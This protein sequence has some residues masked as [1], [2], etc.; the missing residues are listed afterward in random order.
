MLQTN[1]H[2]GVLRPYIISGRF[3]DMAS[4]SAM[5]VVAVETSGDDVFEDDRSFLSFAA[6]F[7]ETQ[8]FKDVSGI[9]LFYSKCFESFWKLIFCFK[10][11]HNTML[12]DVL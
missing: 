11:P 12:C 10:N 8:R 4:D 1:S 5:A 9:D 2:F 6:A 3:Y 7:A